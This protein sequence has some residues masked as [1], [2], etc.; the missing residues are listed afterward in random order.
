MSTS[1]R[2]PL[3]LDGEP[4]TFDLMWARYQA[5]TPE[6]KGLAL[7]GTPEEQNRIASAIVGEPVDVARI[8]ES[9]T[10]SDPEFNDLL[11]KVYGNIGCVR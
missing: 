2:R 6:E 4:D 9:V 7:H 1:P 5:L 3:V 8:R 10:F 11:R